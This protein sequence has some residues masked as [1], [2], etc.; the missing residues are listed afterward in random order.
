MLG[1]ICVLQTGRD[2]SLKHKNCIA[3]HPKAVKNIIPICL[4]TKIAGSWL[5][6]NV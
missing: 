3:P 4:S 5:M 1:N 6:V 2:L